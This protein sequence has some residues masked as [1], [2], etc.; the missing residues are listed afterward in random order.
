[1]AEP[2]FP[3]LEYA[4]ENFSGLKAN[5]STI[6]GKEFYDCTFTDCSFQ[7]STF[8]DCKFDGCTFKSCD[9]SLLV[10]TNS[11]FADLHF[12]QCQCIGIN[13]TVAD[14]SRLGIVAPLNFQESAISHSIF[15]GV[16][17]KK[18]QMTNCMAE[19]VDLSEVDLSEANC[20]GTDFSSARFQQTNLTK[21]NLKN[22][23]NYAIDINQN[24]I[25]RATFSLPEA[26][27]LLKGLDIVLAD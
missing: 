12:K 4:E 26:V 1:M 24:T 17:L 6:R 18:S 25:K 14:W 5:Q 16:T 15:M 22:A 8:Y 7:E 27:S 2:I 9:L 3:E 20:T 10:V 23:T 11:T 13:W 21:A 19:N